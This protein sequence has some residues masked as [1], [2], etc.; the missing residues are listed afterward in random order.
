MRTPGAASGF[1]LIELMIVVA[2]IGILAAIAIPQYQD[3]TIRAQI[4]EALLLAGEIK[5]SIQDYYKD[6]GRFPSNN[7]AAG[8]PAPGHLI[9][10]YVT[11]IEIVDGAMHVRFGNKANAQIAGKVLTLR[12]AYVTANPSSPLAWNCGRSPPPNGMTAAGQDRTDVLNVH[13]PS[14]CRP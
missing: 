8:A 11:D 14:A 5:P 6:R 13:L 4:A 10:N 9:G 3:Y 7:D 2:I 1:T 12:P